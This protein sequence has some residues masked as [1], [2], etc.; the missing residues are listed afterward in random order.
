MRVALL[1]FVF[2]EGARLDMA[3]THTITRNYKDQSP[4]A[5]QLVE[6]ISGNT[7]NN[8]DGSIAVGANTL[9]PWAT[10]RANLRSLLISSDVAI[11][12][13]TNNPSG[14]S[15]QDTIPIAAGQSL[16][17]TLATDLIARCPFSANVTAIYV[18]NAAGGA[19]AFKI[20][21][22]EVQ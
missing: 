10:T 17:W 6:A 14:S 15:P 7:E 1:E 11:T 9:V 16:I 13:F 5:I 22:V 8:Y 19:S 3:I 12:V 18:T 20:R 2:N 21:C 4:N